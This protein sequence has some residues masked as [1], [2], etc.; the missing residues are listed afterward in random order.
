MR[1]CKEYCRF[2]EACDKFYPGIE[3]EDGLDPNDCPVAWKIEDLSNDSVPFYDPDEIPE[4][5]EERL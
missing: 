5:E 1:N 4:E 3:G 2:R